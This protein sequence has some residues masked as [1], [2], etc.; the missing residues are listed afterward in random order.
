M[1]KL[2]IITATAVLALTLHATAA[3]A[4]P[5]FSGGDGSASTPY[6]IVAPAD[7]AALA[8]LVNDPATNA[9]FA[10]RH[11]RLASDIDLSGYAN[12]TPVGVGLI[13]AG[14]RDDRLTFRGVFDGNGGKIVNLKITGAGRAEDSFQG[15]G[16]FGVVEGGTVKNLGLDG[17]SIGVKAGRIGGVVGAA[18][19]G[20]VIENCYMIGNVGGAGSVGGIAGHIDDNSVITNCHVIGDVSGAERVGGVAGYVYGSAV[21]GSY[22]IGKVSEGGSATGAVA[23]HVW[24]SAITE[25]GVFDTGADAGNMLAVIPEYLFDRVATNVKNAPPIVAVVKES[26]AGKITA[27]PNPVNRQSGAVNFFRHGKRIKKGT[28]SIYNSQGKAV[29]KITLA[30]KPTGADSWR[31]AGLWD[32]KDRKGQTVSEGAYAVKGTVFTVDGKKEKVSI[33]LGVR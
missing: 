15:Q 11:Y 32:L 12:W 13:R 8:S 10:D 3:P 19:A 25:S 2:L 26:A 24:N 31:Q 27:G 16:L 4:H 20:S 22:A 29:R 7:L 6:L 30:D 17:V 23:G 9:E 1:N 33:V 18:I 14:G 21:T 5:S 28:L